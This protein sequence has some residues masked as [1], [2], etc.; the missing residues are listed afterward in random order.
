[1]LVATG[2]VASGDYE[3]GKAYEEDAPKVFDEAVDW[4]SEIDVSPEDGNWP[5]NERTVGVQ[6]GQ[7]GKPK[8]GV[9]V[10]FAKFDD[11]FGANVVILD[12]AKGDQESVEVIS[13]TNREGVAYFRLRCKSG[14]EGTRSKFTA[15]VTDEEKKTIG[16]IF[17]VEVF[18]ETR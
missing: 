4:F 12:P 14:D 17:T 3:W 13:K 8:E 10:K 15:T 18:D 9:S 11:S 6:V 16:K 2:Q 7:N 5:G 1:M